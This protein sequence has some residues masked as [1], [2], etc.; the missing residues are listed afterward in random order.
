M[1]SSNQDRIQAVL[2]YILT[3][4]Q[5][6]LSIEALAEIGAFSTYHFHRLL[7][8]YLGE[9]LGSYIKRMRMEKAANWLT[10]TDMPVADIAYQVGYE[11]P[12][13]FTTAFHKHFG[14]SP[15]EFR[16]QRNQPTKKEG[17]ETPEGF[18]FDPVPEFVQLTTQRLACVQ[19][20][21]AYGGAA[22]GQAWGTLLATAGQW[23][24]LTAESLRIGIP[25]E[26]P[27]LSGTDQWLY[28]AC[29]S[30]SQEVEPATPIQ[31]KELAGGH[32][33]R[34]RYQGS[35]E[36]LDV[37]YDRIFNDWL[38][39]SSHQLR[40]A[41]IFDIYRNTPLEVSPDTLITDIH[42]P[43]HYGKD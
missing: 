20:R 28:H 6:P 22:M 31:V 40:D 19:V 35:H 41:E 26:N 17:L 18:A 23:G 38:L 29:V 11:T 4:L 43:I 42:I 15:I 13:A 34:F 16:K 14:L 24:W 12:S 36:H 10:Y 25:H 7:R 5:E 2:D 37:A 39:P 3:H 32:F 21:G 9:P 33:A 8:S 1:A 30:I 27:E